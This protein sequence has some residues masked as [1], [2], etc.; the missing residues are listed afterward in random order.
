MQ[1]T[2]QWV[3]KKAEFHSLESICSHIKP[4]PA[5]YKGDLGT[6]WHLKSAELRDICKLVQFS[7]LLPPPL[8]SE[9]MVILPLGAVVMIPLD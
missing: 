2:D 9:E 1:S 7:E 3:C 4:E 5:L 8:W 6:N